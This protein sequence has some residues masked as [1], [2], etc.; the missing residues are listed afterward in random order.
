MNAL[1]EK[2]IAAT[3]STSTIRHISYE[4]AYGPGFEDM[5]RRVPNIAKAQAWFG[6]Q[7]VRS[8]SDIVAS[9]VDFYRAKAAV[10]SPARATQS[11]PVAVA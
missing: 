7:P 3:G 1:A 5:D 2:V 4:D 8:L 6:Y 10:S 9:V 11:V